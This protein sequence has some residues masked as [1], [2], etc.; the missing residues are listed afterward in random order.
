MNCVFL[1]RKLRERVR[2]LLDIVWFRV[3]LAIVI[4]YLFLLIFSPLEQWYKKQPLCQPEDS[5]WQCFCRQT[6]FVFEINNIEGFSILAASTLYLLESRERRRKSIYEAWQVIDNAAG[7]N[8][9]TSYARI[10]ALEDLNKYGVSLKYLDVPGGY[11]SE[12]DLGGADLSYANL[13]L[14]NLSYSN[15]KYANLCDIQLDGAN[16]S[17]ANLK[18]ANLCYAILCDTQLDGTNLSRANLSYA[19]LGG[20]DLSGAN[21]SRAN[22]SY[23]NLNG[24]T[25]EG[26]QL[27]DAQLEGAQLEGVDLSYAQLEGAQFG[28]ADLLHADLS[29][30]NLRGAIF[31]GTKQLRIEQ[32]K[33][34]NNWE[35]AKY[36]PN[37]RLQLGLS[38]RS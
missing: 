9:P 8:V 4:A 37:F 24:A 20:A 16:L 33:A 12:I 31:I 27:E 38:E 36:D 34:A 32:V 21:L 23:V 25:L 14:A 29:N 22:L 1:F 26:V 30:A 35:Q 19:D 15:L 7:A 2:N 17:R 3:F 28:D 6:L 5:F 13:S 18:R 11:L 10:K